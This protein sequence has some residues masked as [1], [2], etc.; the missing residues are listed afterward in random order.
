MAHRA[1]ENGKDLD[2]QIQL[3]SDVNQTALEDLYRV[4]L[5]AKNLLP[6]SVVC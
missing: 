6:Y 4:D 1:N 3:S 5:I 2:Q